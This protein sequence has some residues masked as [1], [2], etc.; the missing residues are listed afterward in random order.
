MGWIAGE[1]LC[2]AVTNAGGLGMVAMPMLPPDGVGAVLER[3]R[4]ACRGPFGVNFLVPFLD[5]SVL[6][7][8]GALAPVVELFYGWP[9]PS[10]VQRAAPAVVVWQVGSADEARA[11][12]DAGARAVVAQ[13]TEAGGH[14]RGQQPL[15]E[16]LA[17]VRAAVDVPVVASGGLS[18]REAVAA[19]MGAG[20]DAVRIGTALL[21]AKEAD[22][23]PNYLA[24]VLAASG[25]DTELTTAFEAGWPNAP[26]RVLRSSI[27]RA[28][29]EQSDTIGTIDLGGHRIPVP[30]RSPI[31][32]TRSFEGDVGATALYAGTGVGHV[33][34]TRSAAEIIDELLPEDAAQP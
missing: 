9:D 5:P 7:V 1:E 32:A 16:V 19:A 25:A 8:A 12:V 3:L 31:A 6:E 15:V 18:S 13:G 33:R 30:P 29:A 22:V 28:A 14:V 21:A 27:E 2:A 23:H 10:F 24:A 20:A 26:H 34:A 11:A 4:V 17:E